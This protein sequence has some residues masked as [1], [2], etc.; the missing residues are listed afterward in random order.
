[1]GTFAAFLFPITAVSHV[2]FSHIH[3][4][5][6]RL[7]PSASLCFIPLCSSSLLSLSH[8]CSQLDYHSHSDDYQ[9]DQYGWHFLSNGCWV[10]SALW[11]SSS[12]PSLS[13]SQPDMY[14]SFIVLISLLSFYGVIKY[15][16]H[17]WLVLKCLSFCR[18]NSERER[19]ACGPWDHRLHQHQFCCSR[20]PR[21]FLCSHLR[22]PRL[23]SLQ[24]EVGNS[25][26]GMQNTNLLY[27]NFLADF[28]KSSFFFRERSTWFM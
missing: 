21:A 19:Y 27:L 28:H 24:A 22:R 14:S 7:S 26:G 25:S 2:S 18:F 5:D 16:T 11:S 10:L 4:T 15:I 17:W 20:Y 8:D 13:S 3:A 23:L 9:W 1:M 6:R 12:S